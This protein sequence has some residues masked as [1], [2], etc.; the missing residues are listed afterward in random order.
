MDETMKNNKDIVSVTESP[1]AFDNLE[2]MSVK[3]LISG[4]NN[5][6][7]KVHLAVK[8]ALPQIEQLVKKILKRMKKGGRLFIWVPEPVAALEY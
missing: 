4:I 5:E 2:N 6:D 8:N 3:E 7:A 1:S